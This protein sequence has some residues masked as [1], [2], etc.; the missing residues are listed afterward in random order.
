M[1]VLGVALD[2][3]LALDDQFANIA[4]KSLD[5]QGILTRAANAFRGLEW[6]VLRTT[7]DS[8]I[9]SLVRYALGLVETCLPPD[10]FA[11]IDTRIP[12]IAARRITGLS[13]SARIEPPH[14]QAGA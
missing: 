4:S 10:L 3:F 7:H 9:C 12:N 5:R 2:R 1:R 14:Y 8:V 13:R 6:G 11:K